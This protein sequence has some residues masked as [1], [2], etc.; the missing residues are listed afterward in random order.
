MKSLPAILIAAA[1]A[2][3]APLPA[4]VEYAALPYGYAGQARV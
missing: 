2:L 1:A 4:L 3:S